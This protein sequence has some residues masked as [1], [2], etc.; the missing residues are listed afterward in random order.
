MLVY[1]LEDKDGFGPL[2]GRSKAPSILGCIMRHEEPF[3]MARYGKC[4]HSAEVMG[5]RLYSREW[6]FAWDSLERMAEFARFP[7]QVDRAGFVVVAYEI[8]D[9]EEVVTFHDGQL[10]FNTHKANAVGGFWLSRV[11][12][13]LFNEKD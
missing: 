4:S 11:L 9:G 13:I 6:V 3:E 5:A 8:P 12:R 7:R 10:M 1:R 2:C